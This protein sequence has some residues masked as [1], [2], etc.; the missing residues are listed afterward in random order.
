VINYGNGAYFVIGNSK[1]E[2]KR[3]SMAVIA[4]T[5]S[6]FADRPVID[7]TELK[8][9]YD[10]TMEFSAE[11]FRAMMVR[12]AIAQGTVVPPQALKL[13]DA[14]SGDTLLGAVEALGLKLE[15]QKA[16]IEMFV[17]DQALRMPTQN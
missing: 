11:D 4:G 17:I 8:G 15:P 5:L 3:L 13:A 14:A 9:N 6:R 7:M 1:F 10:F 2:G 12:A 16:A